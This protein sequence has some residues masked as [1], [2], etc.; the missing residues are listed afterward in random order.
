MHDD[1]RLM[2]RI[3][4]GDK[5]AF[6][7]LVDSQGPRVHRLARRYAVQE[8]DAED[9]TQEIFVDIFRC[10]ANFRGESTVATWIYRIAINHCLKHQNRATTIDNSMLENPEDDEDLGA[11]P[12]RHA[13]RGELRSRV[14]SALQLLSPLHR[15]I[16]VLHELH[17][18]TY[19]ECA[20]VLKVP[21]GTVK[22]R[23]SN[24]FRA[25]RQSLG[26]Y[27]LDERAEPRPDALGEAL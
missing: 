27:V 7:E 4:Q 3:A 18:L 25:L 17:G 1:K 8:A 14:E 20:G 22:S 10:A 11:D 2:R 19:L 23:L 15:D 6:E 21:I 13:L 12:M 26:D 16:V 5:R 9:L 24:A